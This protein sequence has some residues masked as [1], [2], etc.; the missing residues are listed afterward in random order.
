MGGVYGA[1]S[2]SGMAQ[3]RAS[4]GGPAS[5]DVPLDPPPVAHRSQ[6]RASE[7]SASSELPEDLLQWTPGADTTRHTAQ[8]EVLVV[9]C[10]GG[11]MQVWNLEYRK[12]AGC[13]LLGVRGVGSLAGSDGRDWHRQN[14]SGLASLQPRVDAVQ[15]NLA[16]AG[17]FWAQRCGWSSGG[18]CQHRGSLRAGPRRIHV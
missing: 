14:I 1:A 13:G 18:V 8:E 7:R 5:F 6:F 11:A 4:R 3:K 2:I 16:R 15:P 10:G 17:Q 9:G 12:I